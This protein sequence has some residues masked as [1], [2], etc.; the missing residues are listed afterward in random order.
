MAR[1]LTKILKN[2]LLQRKFSKTSLENI[3]KHDISYTLTRF[4]EIY[5]TVLDN[6]KKES[7]K[8]KKN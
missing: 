5:Q 2:S 7:K 6:R 8:Q 4:E 1:N 3:K